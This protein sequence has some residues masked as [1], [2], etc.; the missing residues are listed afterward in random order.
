M[1]QNHTADKDKPY[2]CKIC[3]KGFAA[4]GTYLDHQ[5]IHTGEK[6]YK[7]KYCS[8]AFA[9]LGTKAMHQKSH[10]GIKR[11]QKKR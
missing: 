5:N 6:P 9:S 4:K 7:C 1:K 8:A 11:I 3:S 10:L 2:Q